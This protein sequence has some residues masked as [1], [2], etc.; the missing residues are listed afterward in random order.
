M[1]RDVEPDFEAVEALFER[2][3]T[4]LWEKQPWLYTFGVGEMFEQAEMEA[5]EKQQIENPRVWVRVLGHRIGWMPMPVD[6]NPYASLWAL[7]ED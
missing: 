5:E 6:R 3:E 7:D 1:L 2:S 4:E